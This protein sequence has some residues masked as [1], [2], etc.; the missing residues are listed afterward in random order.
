[1][2]PVAPNTRKTDNVPLESVLLRNKYNG[3]GFDTCV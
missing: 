2:V 3:F 1:M